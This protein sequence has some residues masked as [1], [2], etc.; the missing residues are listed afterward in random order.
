MAP[1]LDIDHSAIRCKPRVSQFCIHAF[2]ISVTADAIY[3]SAKPGMQGYGMMGGIQGEVRCFRCSV[4]NN[5]IE[6]AIEITDRR[7]DASDTLDGIQVGMV[8]RIVARYGRVARV[9]CLPGAEQ[10]GSM[11]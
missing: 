6:L 2:Q 3:N 7:E 11:D 1:A 5:F 8:K 10:T 4:H 9:I